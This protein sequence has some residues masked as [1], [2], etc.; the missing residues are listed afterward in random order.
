LEATRELATG[1]GLDSQ[2]KSSEEGDRGVKKRWIRETESAKEMTAV[3]KG[4]EHKQERH[5]C[6][7]ILNLISDISRLRKS[8]QRH[9]S[10][11]FFLILHHATNPAVFDD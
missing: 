8:N 1:D 9:S 5:D 3:P 6:M 7:L 2:K 4:Q 10:S 11:I